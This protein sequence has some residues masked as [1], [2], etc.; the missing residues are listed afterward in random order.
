MIRPLELPTTL[1]LQQAALL[2]KLPGWNESQLEKKLKSLVAKGIVVN[3][4]DGSTKRRISL[5]RLTTI[6]SLDDQEKEL[7]LLL[8]TFVSI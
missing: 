7:W 6:P 8:R 1:A 4:S 2:K 5:Q 3:T